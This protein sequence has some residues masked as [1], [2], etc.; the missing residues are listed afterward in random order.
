MRLSAPSL[1]GVAAVP[2]GPSTFSRWGSLDRLRGRPL[3]QPAPTLL[4]LLHAEHA[5]LPLLCYASLASQDAADKAHD[6]MYL[7]WAR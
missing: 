4:S 2:S 1:G 5:P 3:S 6:T 7:R